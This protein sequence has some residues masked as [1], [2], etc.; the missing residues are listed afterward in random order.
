M[1]IKILSFIFMG[2]YI[3]NCFFLIFLI[4][5]QKG[6]EGSF[7]MSSAQNN[8]KN[9]FLYSQN[10]EYTTYY[11]VNFFLFGALLLGKIWNQL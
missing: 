4:I 10:I 11:S 8:R 9:M 7:K 3:L 1:I 5:L 6:S 2:I